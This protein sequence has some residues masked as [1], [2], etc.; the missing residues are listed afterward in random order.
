MRFDLL[1]CNWRINAHDKSIFLLRS[2]PAS[3]FLKTWLSS[4]MLIDRKCIPPVT[5]VTMIPVFDDIVIVSFI[6]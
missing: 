6:L 5:P 3:G 1:R 2:W 4:D